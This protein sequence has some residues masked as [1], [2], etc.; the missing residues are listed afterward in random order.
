MEDGNESIV[1]IKRPSPQSPICMPRACPPHVMVA[2]SER[3]I[4]HLS[5]GR[6]RRH[7]LRIPGDEGPPRWAWGEV[8]HLSLVSLTGKPIKKPYSVA[9]V[10]TCERC[11]DEHRPSC[12]A[13]WTNGI[14]T[15]IIVIDPQAEQTEKRALRGAEVYRRLAKNYTA[16]EWQRKRRSPSRR[17]HAR[18]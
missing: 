6:K 3:A 9:F 12:P 15:E 18:K 16:A 2:H 17:K 11:G 14:V 7:I 8:T 10:G 1:D 13:C 5:A 4:S